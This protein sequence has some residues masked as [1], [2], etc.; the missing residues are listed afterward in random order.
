MV[1]NPN[2]L[3]LCHQASKKGLEEKQLPITIPEIRLPGESSLL[4]ENCQES[5]AKESLDKYNL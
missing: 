2:L 3:P 4:F 5:S 1:F